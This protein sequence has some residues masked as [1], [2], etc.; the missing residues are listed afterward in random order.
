MKQLP[1]TRSLPRPARSKR[2]K[3][4]E[5]PDRVGLEVCRSCGAAFYRKRWHRSL[6][7]LRAVPH[8]TA[9]T[10]TRCPACEQF[11]N[12]TF[13]G[14]VIVAGVPSEKFDGV[15]RRI[16]TIGAAAERKNPMARILRMD[17]DRQSGAIRVTTSESQLARLIGRGVRE[18]FG[19]KLAIAFSKEESIVRVRLTL[20]R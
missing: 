12:R 19:G 8:R 20:S 4:F 7:A 1:G 15:V 3:A 6:D 18:A 13:E 14:E 11:L 5:R 9:I 2:K 10:S 16:E 17:V